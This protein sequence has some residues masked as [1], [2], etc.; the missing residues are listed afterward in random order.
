MEQSTI[1]FF[2]A[3][4]IIIGAALFAIISNVKHGAKRLDVEKYRTKCL[5]IEQ[6]F[7]K[8]D[9]SSYH[10]A[11]LNADKLVG[12]A[13]TDL[14]I[15]GDTMG[16]KMKFAKNKFSDNNGIWNAHKLRNRIAH[17]TDV[18]VDYNEAKRALL[19]FRKALKDLGAI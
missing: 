11:V 10:L 14:N 4:M 16:E 1:I 8:G 6:S 3:A 13:L 19:N 5:S 17:D 18:R 15:K 7:K 9:E 2:L 12:Q